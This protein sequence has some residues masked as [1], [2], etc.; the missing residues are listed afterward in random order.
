MTHSTPT[1]IRP[2][3]DA[4][5]P[6]WQP[7][8][9]KDYL[10]CCDDPALEQ[11]R[12]FFNQGYLLIYLG[13][14]GINHARFNS[15]L[16]MLFLSW[17]AQKGQ[18]F[19]ELGGCVIEKPKRQAASPDKIVYIG[20]GSPRWKEGEPR[21][22]NLTQWR[23]PDLVGEVADTTLATDLDEKKELYAALE[24]PEYWVVD[25]R[26]ERVL[27]F[28]LQEDGK[29]QQCE[30]SVALEGLP[31]S[32]IERTLAQLNQGNNGSAAFWFAQQIANL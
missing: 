1:G 15:L 14:E 31:I 20:E 23:V 21:R 2:I 6:Q 16:T 29:Y 22:I 4:P 26:G 27:A 18:S 25:I 30:D 28:R 13:N 10:A 7:A 11:A 3:L 8:T 12:L 32:L 5:L 19:D 24:I 17:F 9:W